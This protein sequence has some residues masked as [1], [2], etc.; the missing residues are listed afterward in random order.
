MPPKIQ[1]LI[2]EDNPNDAELLV[3]ELQRA[4]FDFDWQRVDTE[5]EYLARLNAGLHLI[6]SDYEMPLFSGLRALELLNQQPVLEI[7]SIMVSGTIGE[8][9][10]VA[11]IKQGAADYLLKDLSLIH[12]SPA[13][14]GGISA[15]ANS[16][17]DRRG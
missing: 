6:L 2:V 9:T 15:T 5:P 16:T 13:E 10:A 4:G 11:A 7:P 12:I 3:R 14:T 17:L 8:E 1:I